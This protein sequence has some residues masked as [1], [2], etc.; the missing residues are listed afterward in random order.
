MYGFGP[1]KA[2]GAAVHT[3]TE[4]SG[5]RSAGHEEDQWRVGEIVCGVES[6]VVRVVKA[7]DACVSVG[8]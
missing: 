3:R 8:R 4:A 6:D 2:V 1:F 5:I 7:G